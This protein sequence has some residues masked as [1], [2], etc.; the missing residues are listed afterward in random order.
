[1]RLLADDLA[2]LANASRHELIGVSSDKMSNAP[3][4]GVAQLTYYL[5]VVHSE[6][7]EGQ[8]RSHNMT[9]P[10]CGGPT[11]FAFVDELTTLADGANT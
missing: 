4:C 3:G 10:N 2:D 6:P 1:M 9:E 11:Y 5:A 8:N 7:N